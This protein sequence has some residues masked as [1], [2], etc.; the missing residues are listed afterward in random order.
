MRKA[1]SSNGW[2]KFGKVPPRISKSSIFLQANNFEMVA[3]KPATPTNMKQD[4]TLWRDKESKWK[5]INLQS[6]RITFKAKGLHIAPIQPAPNAHQQRELEQKQL[7]ERARKAKLE[8]EA[9]KKEAKKKQDEH[10][11]MQQ[12]RS[13][14]QVKSMWVAKHLKRMAKRRGEPMPTTNQIRKARE[15]K[16]KKLTGKTSL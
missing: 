16:S 12:K 11:R 5:A 10:N 7:Q 6:V 13:E 8:I 15:I 2:Q 14:S 9:H 1:A 3:T 4:K